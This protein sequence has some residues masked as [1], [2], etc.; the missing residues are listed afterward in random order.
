MAGHDCKNVLHELYDFLDGELTV[1]RRAQ[2]QQH[3]EACPPCFEG[4]DFEA[5]LR[6]V[7]ARKCTE[8][9]PDSLRLRIASAIEIEAVRADLA[10]PASGPATGASP[11]GRAGPL[12]GGPNHLRA[13]RR[14]MDPPAG[15]TGPL[16]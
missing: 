2:I 8:R 12:A 11:L 7:V 16:R 13:G 1:E 9:V 15:T 10:T 5:E 3:L 4:F 14:P 6:Q